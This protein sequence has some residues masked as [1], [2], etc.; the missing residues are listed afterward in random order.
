M[1]G[2]ALSVR[3]IRSGL[4]DAFRHHERIARMSKTE[5]GGEVA[6]VL[7]LR[8]DQRSGTTLDLAMV[9]LFSFRP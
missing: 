7:G 6:P 1:L 4:S 5:I 2:F 3:P 8:F 9:A